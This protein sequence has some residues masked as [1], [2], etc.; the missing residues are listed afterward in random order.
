MN[1]SKKSHDLVRQNEINVQ[2]SQKHDV[3][4]Q[5][6]STLYFQV[7]LILCLLASY[8][9]LEMS[10]EGSKELVYVTHEKDD[11]I[12]EVDPKIY[13]IVKEVKHVPKEEIVKPK[14]KN[15]DFK[16]VDDLEEIK[17]V[18]A[19]LVDVVVPPNKK[20]VLSTDDPSL[21]IEDIEPIINIMAVQQVPIFPGCEKETNNEGRRKCLS[22]KLSKLVQRKFDTDV[23]TDLGITGKQ[24]IYVSFKINKLGEVEI[25]ETKAKHT[26][27]EK[28]ANRVV[29]K[30]PTMQPGKNNNKPVVVSYMLPINFNIQ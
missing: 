12:Y 21:V 7:G 13:K 18:E 6:N 9:A 11:S 1:N 29:G 19:K 28:E 15:P 16:I 20:P 17:K 3:N 5:K 24:K 25:I 8:G 26:A 27:L 23:A 4:L 10:F 2:K 30:I 14:P 22:E